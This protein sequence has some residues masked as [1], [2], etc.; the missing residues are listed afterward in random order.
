MEKTDVLESGQELQREFARTLDRRFALLAVLEWHAAI[1]AALLVTPFTWSGES[2]SLH[3]HV[4][5][6]LV[7]GG[8]IASFPVLCIRLKP[9]APWI[10]YINAAA[11]MLM[12]GLLV[13]VTGGHIETHFAYFGLLAFLSFYR[14]WRVL[15]TA[16]TVA[17]LDHIL[18]GMYWPQSMYGVPSVLI[19]RPL[20]HSAWVIFEVVFLVDFIR[21]AH[22]E[23]ERNSAMMRKK[24]LE[25]QESERRYRTL[26]ELSP[27][28]MWLYDPDT[29]RFVAVNRQ[30]VSKYLY[31][32]A[33]FLSMRVT[34]IFAQEDAEAFRALRENVQNGPIPMRQWR[35]KKKDGSIF[36]VEA[37]SHDV[38]WKDRRAILVLSA[39]VSARVRAERERE[40][41]EGQ[42][43]H[44]QKLESIG[45]LASGIAHEINTPTQYVGDNLHFLTESLG[46]I[47]ELLDLESRML[48]EL[49]QYGP[50]QPMAVALREAMDN[51]DLPYLDQE[52][53]KALEQS[54]DG[55]NRIATLVKAM[56]EFS[57]PGR[58]EKA[59]QDI[60][61]AIRNTV[62]V[63]RHEWKYVAD[64]ELDLDESLPKVPCFVNDLNQVIL[65]L[66]VNA[67]HAIHEVPNRAGKGQITIRTRWQGKTAEICIEDTG[68]GIPVE[69]RSRI[70]EPFFT[71]KAVGKGTG[72][73][74]A[75]AHSIISDKHGGTITFETKLGK[76]T[77]FFIR[78]PLATDPIA[79][80]ESEDGAP[81]LTQLGSR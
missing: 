46:Q 6:A 10:R 20:E 7:L 37:V 67:A 3:P 38:E 52:I 35:H 62:A 5:F 11:Q 64:L 1:A 74:L 12:A 28:S 76:G 8:I 21:R 55:V 57:H 41:M 43:R 69:A 39:D 36:E 18:R 61:Q 14:D 51:V 65:N 45:Q 29:L 24:T 56:K 49:E 68:A 47:R 13:H 70:F 40:E 44:A 71:T 16:T 53:P 79:P 58:K 30:A 19:W 27:M 81:V 75:I 17:A 22:L 2:R 54:I 42:L 23:A 80:D 25:L 63:A 73:G 31:S 33:E 9:E 32:E 72:Q 26:F 34:D 59:P 77:T 66:I 15:A 48:P 60:N 4:W 50:L 78:L